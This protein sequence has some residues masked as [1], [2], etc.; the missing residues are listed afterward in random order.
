M[1]DSTTSL[2]GVAMRCSVAGLNPGAWNILG[3]TCAESLIV[4]LKYLEKV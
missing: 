1:N 2:K 3:E 4:G